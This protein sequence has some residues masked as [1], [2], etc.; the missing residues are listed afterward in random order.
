MII[1]SID[2]S[3]VYLQIEEKI[4]FNKVIDFIMEK[5][6]K[7]PEFDSINEAFNNIGKRLR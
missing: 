6:I 2:S 3:G 1:I 4:N 7:D 5:E